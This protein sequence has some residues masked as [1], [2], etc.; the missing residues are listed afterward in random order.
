[1]KNRRAFRTRYEYFE[2]III[3]FN[4]INNLAIFQAYTNKFL[5]KLINIFY[6]IYLNNIL[7]FLISKNEYLNYVK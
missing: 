2:Y 4:L 5:I 6:I 1:M 3:L 7:I